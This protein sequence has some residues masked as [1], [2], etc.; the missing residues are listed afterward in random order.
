[1]IKYV[2]FVGGHVESAEQ[3]CVSSQTKICIARRESLPS[4]S[5]IVH[6]VNMLVSH[7]EKRVSYITNGIKQSYDASVKLNAD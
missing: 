4:C 3:E 5:V 2:G 6:Y 1:M 7:I